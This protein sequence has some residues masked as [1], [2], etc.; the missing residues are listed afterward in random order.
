MFGKSFFLGEYMSVIQDKNY[1]LNKLGAIGSKYLLANGYFGYRGTMEEDGPKEFVA[2]NVNGLFDKNAG[3]TMETVNVFNP[4]MTRCYINKELIQRNN[5]NKN[6]H[7]IRINLNLGLFNRQTVFEYD[8]VKIKIRSERFI[9]QENK[10]MIYSR[11][12]ISADKEVDIEMFNGIDTEIWNM[13]GMHLLTGKKV[14]DGQKIIVAGKTRSTHKQLLVGLM[15]V[16]NFR[17]RDN[18]FDKA[19]FKY[20]M[21]LEPDK[22]YEIDKYACIMHSEDVN[23]DKINELLDN[24]K[25][26]GYDELLERNRLKWLELWHDA[27]VNAI[28]NDYVNRISQYAVFQLVQNRP[29]S[30]KTGVAFKGLSGQFNNSSISW[31]NEF[32]LF[33]FYL[34]HFPEA[35]RNMLVNRINGLKEAKKLAKHFDLEGAFYPSFAS[36][37]GKPIDLKT[38]VR[39]YI[40]VGAMIVYA[41]YDYYFRTEDYEIIR[42]GGLEMAL[43]CARLYV[44][45]AELND[46]KTHYDFPHASGID[47]NHYDVTNSAFTNRLIK[48]N[49][50]VLLKM[51]AIVK[52]KDKDYWQQLFDENDY[53]TMIETMRKIRRKFYLKNPNIKNVMEQFDGYFNLQDVSLK[54]WRFLSKEPEFDRTRYQI[55][56][57]PEVFAIS[58]LFPTEYDLNVKK[59][60]Y[61]Y[62]FN[63]LSSRLYISKTMSLLTAVEIGYTRRGYRQFLKLGDMNLSSSDIFVYGLDL[64]HLAAIYVS[65]VYGFAGLRFEDNLISCNLWLPKDI[66]RLEFNIKNNNNQGAV[67]IKRNISLINWE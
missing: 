35:A 4:L 10:F 27:G 62:Y 33:P 56:E 32:L 23:L 60:N 16:R 14:K 3:E 8:D 19:Y 20:E 61:E 2:V 43:E 59:A 12:Q 11:Y 44:N 7:I 21:K 55:I 66:R 1:D 47:H 24:A 6:T 64:I 38:E 18:S 45:L 48:N 50:D 53:H 46:T 42:N 5:E 57:N 52:Y 26:I 54:E 49:F 41:L 17:H 28:N 13:Q 34:N 39:E 15:S 30:E 63:R 9:D 37:S 67:K 31:F 58:F 22:I 51:I 40:H 25:D 29:I 65:L 36:S